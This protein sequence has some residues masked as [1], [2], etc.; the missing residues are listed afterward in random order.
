[1]PDHPSDLAALFTA[2]RTWR[3]A[4]PTATLAEIEQA[5][6]RQVAAVQRDLMAAVLD[7]E[8]EFPTVCPTCGDTLVRNGTTT[9][10]V[11]VGHGE[12]LTITNP[13][14]RCSAT[15]RPASTIVPVLSSR[16]QSV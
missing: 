8:V 14:L 16:P 7:Q 10:S 4:H 5:A 3:S 9:R 11:T 12:H 13:R 2:M 15:R 1:M 6:A